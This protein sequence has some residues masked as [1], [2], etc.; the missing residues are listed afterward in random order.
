MMSPFPFSTSEDTT[1]GQVMSITET[2][3]LP[4]PRFLVG[5]A[6]T[7]WKGVMVRNTPAEQANVRAFALDDRLGGVTMNVFEFELAA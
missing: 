6:R 3:D 2:V 5:R 4:I 1:K 7:H